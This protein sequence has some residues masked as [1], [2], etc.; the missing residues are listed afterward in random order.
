VSAPTRGVVL[1]PG[2][3]AALKGDDQ[4]QWWYHESRF[5]Q[6]LGQQGLRLADPEPFV[7]TTRIDGVKWWPWQW[8]RRD[9]H[10]DWKAAGLNLKRYLST[11][12][13]E[14]RNLIAHSHGGQVALYAAFYGAI[15]RR[16]V[17]V[18][19]PVREDIERHIV[20]GA[21]RHI[22][23]WRHIYAPDGDRTQLFG[24]LFDGRAGAR[25]WFK[26]ANCN[27]PIPGAG[28][29]KVLNEPEW[30]PRLSDPYN[31]V[32]RGQSVIEFLKDDAS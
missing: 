26:D 2:T 8:F 7:W 5:V 30:F 13:F 18:S 32:W 17:T 9:D 16:L 21:R 23:L 28:H 10:T 22:V 19:T 27:Q 14:D 15:I 1:V 29:S 12:P 11:I 4:K 31:P 24:S 3:H 25:R 6:F 20:E